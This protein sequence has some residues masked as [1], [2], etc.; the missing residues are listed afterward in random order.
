MRGKS[1][2]KKLR[3]VIF[4]SYA[5][6]YVGSGLGQVALVQAES[7]AKLGHEVV[8][9]SSNI[10][11]TKKR[12]KRNGVLHIKLS[13]TNFLD[14]FQIPVPI[15]LLNR[16]VLSHIKHADVV[17]AH[18]MLY[19]YSLQAALAAKIFA[20]P[21]VLTQ[22]AGF[23]SYPSQVINFLQSLTNRT[24]GR[25]VLKL[26]SE[27]I[28]VNEEV[29]NWLRTNGKSVV[30]LMNGVNT[31]LFYP[32]SEKRKRQIRKKYGLP[33]NKKIVL[34]VGRLVEKKGFHR[35]YETRNNDYLTVIVGGGKVPESMVAEEEKVLFLGTLP[36]EKLS[37]I[38]QTS[39]VFVLPSDCEG[40]PLSIQEAMACGMPIITSNL[41]GFD[42]Y[43]DKR[44]VKF[45]NPT[46][47]EIR[48]AI[49]QV[50]SDKKTRGAMIDYSLRTTTAKA[51]WGENIARLLDIYKRVIK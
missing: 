41:P 50:L 33:V 21:F 2:G 6:P 35:L 19:S 24:L 4:V 39:D 40:F 8:L 32:A 34:H 44:F 12:F 14:K 46:T 47:E 31:D 29:K 20:K 48:N 18:D 42:K 43:L 27:I 9:V 7:L 36:Q 17:H 45:I 49:S 28:V 15:F 10:P 11:A 5:Y 26:S 37:E 1:R 25:L 3:I 51:S 22:H 13:S 30:T 38:Y 16:E 23:I